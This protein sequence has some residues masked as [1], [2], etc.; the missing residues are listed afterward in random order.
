M[1]GWRIGYA[2]A[3]EAIMKTMVKFQ[4]NVVSCVNTPTQF[5]AIEALNGDQTFLKEMISQYE[6]RRNLLIDGINDIEK[7]SAIRPKGAFYAFVNIKD[8]GLTSWD[9][10]LRL[11]EQKH[12]VTVPG[13][14]FG[15][16]GEGFIRISYAASIE[17]IN[18]GIEKM[19]DFVNNL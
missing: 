5:A 16:A 3:D 11:L 8:T 1:T 18:L 14:A 17:K 4:E 13:T 2:V 15:E 19:R 12:V 7:L 9:F 6:K 10:S